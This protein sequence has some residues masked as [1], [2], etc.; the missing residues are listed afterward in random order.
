MFSVP[1][2]IIR[3]HYNVLCLCINK[4]ACVYKENGRDSA[5]G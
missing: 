1:N 2:T 3:V 5:V 4:N